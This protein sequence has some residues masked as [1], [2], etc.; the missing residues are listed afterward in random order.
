M[1]NLLPK[2]YHGVASA[3]NKLDGPRPGTR[4]PVEYKVSYVNKSYADITVG[5]R[6][7]FSYTIPAG[8][9]RFGETFIIR[10]EFALSPNV[11]IDVEK[12]LRQ[13]REDSCA[14]LAAMKHSIV[15]SSP[16]FRNG[17]TLI[18][19]DYPITLEELKK[20]GG[21]VYYSEIDQVLSL[22]SG[23][24]VPVHPY[25]D[26]GRSAYA[27]DS[28]GTR[29][30]GFLY[31]LEVVDNENRQGTRFVNINGSVYP[32]SPVFDY[33]RREGVYVQTHGHLDEFNNPTSTRRRVS[34]AEAG[35]ELGVWQT[36]E[37]AVTLGNLERKH[38]IALSERAAE[39]VRL[40]NELENVRHERELE[41]VQRDK[42][43]E[44]DDDLRQ[45]HQQQLAMQREAETHALELRRFETKD[46]FEE[47]A[48]QR[49]DTSDIIKVLPSAVVGLG[50]IAMAMKSFLNR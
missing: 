34:F 25:S 35:K 39:V 20:Y 15:A 17:G 1:R 4:S 6:S 32:L 26:R 11:R 43:R 50:A 16:K 36:H 7:G 31:N 49:K 29:S 12:L 45:R 2:V 19:V 47:R 28:H 48:Y 37:E 40:K 41:K 14:E 46:R 30:V 24:D 21:S 9:D 10:V 18:T 3:G 33:G 22:S 8:D 38:E 42:E 44:R 13:V 27:E 23:N 5:M